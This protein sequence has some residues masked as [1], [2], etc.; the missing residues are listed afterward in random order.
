MNETLAIFLQA[1]NFRKIKFFEDLASGEMSLDQFLLTQE[2]FYHAVTG[3]SVP[4]ALVI[5]GIPEHENRVKIL[6]NMGETQGTTFTELL[7]RL[8]GKASITIPLAQEEVLLFNSTLDTICRNQHYLKGVAALGMIERMF[9]DI[10]GFMGNTIVE[11]GW[12]PKERI[13]HYNVNPKLDT[14]HAEDFFSI[15]RS[16]Y[17]NHREIIDEGLMLGAI[18]LLK[19]F[20]QLGEKVKN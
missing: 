15:L 10:S 4:L 9:A 5:A 3:F 7:K 11:R 14:A 13:I 16:H 8:S 17:E 2:Q 20:E 19:L 12:L 6:K 1:Y 18:T